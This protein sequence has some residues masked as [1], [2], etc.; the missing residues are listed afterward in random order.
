MRRVVLLV[1]CATLAGCGSSG[2]KRLSRDE[3]ARRA[4]AI[5]GRYH[6]LIATFGTPSGT[7]ELARVA[8]R[9]LRALD[10]AVADLRGLRPPTSEQPLA[11]GWLTSLSTLRGDVV[12]LRARA[13]ANDLAGIRRLVGP[14]QQHNRTSNGFAARLGMTVCSKDAG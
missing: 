4:D 3:Y 12:K 11:R 7:R 5:C 6:R 2:N 1:L 14:A 9:T 8:D 13:R 10:T